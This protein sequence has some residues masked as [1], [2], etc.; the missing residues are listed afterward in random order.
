MTEEGM[1]E[2]GE[3]GKAKD[4]NEY[5]QLYGDKPEKRLVLI[6]ENTNAIAQQI[7]LWS[8]FVLR[9]TFIEEKP[10]TNKKQ[11]KYK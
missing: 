9:K 11:T 4:M 10:D 2:E 3:M 6:S 8:N 5:T 7:Q 1:V